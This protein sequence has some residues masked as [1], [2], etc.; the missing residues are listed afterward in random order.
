[1]SARLNL[2]LWSLALVVIGAGCQTP[3]TRSG[4]PSVPRGEYLKP[5]FDGRTWILI[6]RDAQAHKTLSEYLPLGQSP[7]V[8]TESYGGTFV[9]EGTHKGSVTNEYESFIR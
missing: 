6:N 4:L 8:W 5:K 2:V 7:L 9:V 1:M 3:L